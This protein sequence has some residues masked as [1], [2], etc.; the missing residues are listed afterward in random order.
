MINSGRTVFNPVQLHLLKMF[1][2]NDTPEALDTLRVA[3][4]KFYAEQ[5]A[6]QL[7]KMWD[8]GKITQ[9]ELDKLEFEHL[10]SEK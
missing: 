5:L 6:K 9:Q 1:E 3:L 7:N 10:R 4:T 8:E 2:R